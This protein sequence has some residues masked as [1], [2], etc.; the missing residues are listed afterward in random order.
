MHSYLFYMYKAPSERNS[1]LRY[2]NLR[3]R[4]QLQQPNNLRKDEY[5]YWDEKVS[6]DHNIYGFILI[7]K[8][9]VN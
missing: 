6:V 7:L 1:F 5:M 4:F 8:L 3:H 9:N 2:L